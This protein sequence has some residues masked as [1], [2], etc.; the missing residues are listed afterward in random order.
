MTS[1]A[2]AT[3]TTRKLVLR[4][5]INDLSFAE[6]S[7]DARMEH[8]R[9]EGRRALAL[10]DSEP[11]AVVRANAGG[12]Y[13]SAVLAGVQADSERVWRT[14]VDGSAGVAS[15][16]YKA[17]IAITGHAKAPWTAR[18]VGGKGLATTYPFAPLC[19]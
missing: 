19:Q 3:T 18:A 15:S 5:T 4:F 6:A 16:W 17:S 10:A 2:A 9:R 11:M 1:P 12:P 14:V 13:G 8:E 7:V